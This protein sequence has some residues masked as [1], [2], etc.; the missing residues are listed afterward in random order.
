MLMMNPRNEHLLFL[1]WLAVVAWAA[2]LFA[3][4][5]GCTAIY[6]QSHYIPETTDDLTLLVQSSKKPSQDYIYSTVEH[7][8]VQ[9]D[10]GPYR[11]EFPAY[12]TIRQELIMVG[13][14]IF[15]IFP[16]GLFDML[17][18]P[19]PDDKD[20][21]VDVFFIDRSQADLR[22]GDVIIINPD[23]DRGVE[24][25]PEELLSA[26]ASRSDVRL[27]YHFGT[28]Y[29]STFKLMLGRRLYAGGVSPMPSVTFERKYGMA[30][31]FGIWY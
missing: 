29:P 17:F 31:N 1:R 24:L 27:K 15:P 14:L 2:C 11:F 18:Y 20:V 10:H 16:L 9:F 12:R 13:P 26:R 5:G 21:L 8:I 7:T 23:E 30:V 19:E 6:S 22:P 28:H 25:I 4:V 3:G